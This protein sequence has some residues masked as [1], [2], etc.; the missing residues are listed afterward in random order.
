M[1]VDMGDW[2][3]PFAAAPSP[4][5]AP[6]TASRAGKLPPLAAQKT[7]R[8]TDTNDLQGRQALALHFT[9]PSD[10]PLSHQVRSRARLRPPP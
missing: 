8:G 9:V 7:D 10:R 5:R 3:A 6:P 2:L 4:A 1:A